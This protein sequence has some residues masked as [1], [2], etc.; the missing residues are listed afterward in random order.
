MYLVSSVNITFIMSLLQQ[1]VKINTGFT[2]LCYNHCHE[3]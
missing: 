1:Q 2:S 3:I